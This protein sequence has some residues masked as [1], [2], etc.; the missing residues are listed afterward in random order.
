MR[1]WEGTS[2]S[3]AAALNSFQ[4]VALFSAKI[5]SA[6]RPGVSAVHCSATALA[7][8]LGRALGITSLISGPC[9]VLLTVIV[10]G[11]PPATLITSSRVSSLTCSPWYRYVSPVTCSRNRSATSGPRFVK[12]QAILSV[13]PMTTPG[14]PAKVN[15]VTSYGH[16]SVIARQCSP[17]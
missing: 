1:F 10:T 14:S 15:P 11:D 13:C 6:V 12:P 4:S 17:A 3:E 9:R 8:P 16:A 2:N 5:A 7:S